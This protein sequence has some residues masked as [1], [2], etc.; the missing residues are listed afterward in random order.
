MAFIN[1]S[2]PTTNA[3]LQISTAT[4]SSPT[5]GYTVPAL[6]DITINNSAGV[7][8]WQQLDQFGVLSVSTPATN[9]VSGNFVVDPTT[10]FTGA[11][12]I[13]GIFDLSND[14][15]TVNFRVYFN[16]TG[17]NAKYVSG[18]GF[19]NNL[20]PTVN[21]SAPVWV[22]PISIAVDGDLTVGTV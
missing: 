18:T 9:Q 12:S 22:S 7:Y 11:N 10:F 17:T 20:A 16:G 2:A 19:I 15:Y 6:T 5:S 1:V 8:N 21:P 14:A 13:P 3:I 4:I